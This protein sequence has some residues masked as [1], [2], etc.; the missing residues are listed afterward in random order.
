MKQVK[1]SDMGSNHNRNIESNSCRDGVLLLFNKREAEIARSWSR[2]ALTK[3]LVES[4][5]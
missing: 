1:G 4:K 5:N 2:A 3:D